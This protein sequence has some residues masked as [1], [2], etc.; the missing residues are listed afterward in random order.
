[1]AKNKNIKLLPS[2]IYSHDTIIIK[3]MNLMPLT[4]ENPAKLFV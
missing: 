3:T 4:E 1:M 2:N